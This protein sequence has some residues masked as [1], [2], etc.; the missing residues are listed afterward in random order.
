[1]CRLK[2]LDQEKLA[3]IQKSYSE[4]LARPTFT[5]TPAMDRLQE[6]Q[7]GIG[8]LQSILK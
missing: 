5:H 2:Y 4:E 6:A 7:K 8:E 3:G 1:M